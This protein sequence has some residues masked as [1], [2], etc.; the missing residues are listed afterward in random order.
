MSPA[1][2]P[3]KIVAT[4]VGYDG[5]NGI[6]AAVGFETWADATPRWQTSARCRVEA[7][8]K[9]GS[10]FE[11]ELP[12]I[13]PLVER[14]CAE[15]GAGVVVVDGYVDLGSRPGLGRHLSDA[16]RSRGIEAVIVGVAKNPFEGAPAAELRRGGSERPLFVTACGVDLPTATGWIRSMHGPHRM[17]TLLRLVD[18]L[19]RGI[20]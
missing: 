1:V 18:Q 9:P 20:P 6:A 13:L 11:R 16:L 7:A 2:S 15:Q 17:P 5:P 14:A 4:D 8:Y 10:F 12:C 19:A 3:A